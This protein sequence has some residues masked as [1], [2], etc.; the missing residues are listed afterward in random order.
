ML[1]HVSTLANFGSF[2][3][4]D[5]FVVLVIGLLLFG[6]KLPEVGKNLGK[7]IVEFKKGLNGSYSADERVEEP[8]E[9]E[10][11]APPRRLASGNSNGGRVSASQGRRRLAESRDSEEV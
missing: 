1:S 10:R 8:Q 4:F 7:T 2:F 5:G 3:G 9:E 6:R 11:P